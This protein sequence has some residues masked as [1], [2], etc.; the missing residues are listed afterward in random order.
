MPTR[1]NID[2]LDVL[3]FTKSYSGYLNNTAR[4]EIKTQATAVFG[5]VTIPLRD[6]ISLFVGGR[7]S[8]HDKPYNYIGGTDAPRSSLGVS[9]FFYK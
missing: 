1:A 9:S 7:Y 5:N 2:G 6:D 3:N 8:V 4:M